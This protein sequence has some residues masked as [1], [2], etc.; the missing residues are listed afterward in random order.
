MT[1]DCA[2][3][4]LMWALGQTKNPKRVRELMEKNITGEMSDGE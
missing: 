3:V 2:V 1:Y 4:K